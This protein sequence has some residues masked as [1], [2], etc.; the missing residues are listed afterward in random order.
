[1]NRHVLV[2]VSD[3]PSYLYGVRFVAGFF[4]NVEKLKVTLFYVAPPE[5]MAGKKEEDGEKELIARVK[6]ALATA[7]HILVQNGF[8]RE[9]I[10]FK[11]TSR[12]FGTVKD[13]IREGRQGLYDAVVLGRR[14][15]TIFE[16]LFSYSVSREILERP[17]P[18]PV[19][20]CRE[21]E[22][23]RRGCLVCVDGSEAAFA[24]TDHV[25]FML[26]EESL[27]HI[28][29]L[30]VLE[31]REKEEEGAGILEKAVE[32]L[33][34]NGVPAE[35]ISVEMVAGGK[36]ADVILDKLKREKY[37]VVAMGKTGRGEKKGWFRGSCCDVILNHLKGFCLWVGR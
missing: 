28:T 15:Y 9:N 17:I 34:E 1:M 23:D 36:P 21:F 7:E 2:T 25:G 20:I 31:T 10:E 5:A 11:I 33:R 22:K 19:W 27:H 35:R 14:G 30:H 4:R 37:A 16:K 13:I 26:S 18:F 12:K 29:V 24:V 32:M 6:E 8:K 3:N